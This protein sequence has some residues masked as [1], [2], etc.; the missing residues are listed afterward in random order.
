MSWSSLLRNIVASTAGRVG[1]D[2]EAGRRPECEN[3]VVKRKCTLA[4]PRLIATDS[5]CAREYVGSERHLRIP[6]LSLVVN[7]RL[8]R[9]LRNRVRNICRNSQISALKL[10]CVRPSALYHFKRKHYYYYCKF[11][12]RSFVCSIR[13]LFRSISLKQP[14]AQN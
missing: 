10:C 9:P 4:Y 3:R 5:T 2:P 6:G 12:F 1:K 14:H 8:T 7:I 13:F 11:R